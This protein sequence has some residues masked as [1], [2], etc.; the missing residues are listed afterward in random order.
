[1]DSRWVMCADE[2]TGASRARQRR[3]RRHQMTVEF[4]TASFAQSD[5]SLN[6]HSLESG[7]SHSV[8]GDGSNNT[9]TLS[10]DNNEHQLSFLSSGCD[11]RN[12]LLCRVYT[13]CPKNDTDLA[14]ITSSKVERF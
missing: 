11:T 5:I 13:L 9:G 14:A 8:V 12:T 4:L 2:L 1:M 6:K 10:K 3:F 7:R